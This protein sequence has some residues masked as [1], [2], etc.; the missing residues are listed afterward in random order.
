MIREDVTT[1]Q[2]FAWYVRTRPG[3]ES[4][5]TGGHPF[6]GVESKYR[7]LCWPIGPAEPGVR[8]RG[9]G[10]AFLV[11]TPADF[12]TFGPPGWAG[13]G[14]SSRPNSTA[15]G[16]RTAASGSSAWSGTGPGGGPWRNASSRPSPGHRGTRDRRPTAQPEL[17]EPWASARRTS[18]RARG[19]SMG[20]GEARELRASRGTS[21]LRDEAGPC[22]RNEV[23][24]HP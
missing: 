4:P 13:P 17:A 2:G 10:P 1:L 23:L 18:G 11:I 16:P 3:S 22:G 20:P 21:R 7:P 12:L 24:P 8:N 6:D 14:R 15:S 5:G 9:P 19:A